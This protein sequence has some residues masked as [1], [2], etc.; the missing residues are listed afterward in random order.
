MFGNAAPP[1]SLLREESRERSSL[2]SC[3]LPARARGGGERPCLD[4]A[5]KDTCKTHNF[6]ETLH[7][8]ELGGFSDKHGLRYI[9]SIRYAVQLKPRSC[10]GICGASSGKSTRLQEAPRQLQPHCSLL[11]PPGLPPSRKALFV[12]TT[13]LQAGAPTS[14]QAAQ[15]LLAIA[16]TSLIPLGS[17]KSIS[18]TCPQPLP[19]FASPFTCISA[20]PTSPLWVPVPSSHW[21]P[22]HPGEWA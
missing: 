21:S 6:L 5:F 18:Q 17:P 14:T 22:A 20:L 11:P 9:G 12:P 8:L 4:W 3:Y 2:L 13:L 16:R 10:C 15:H 19:S 7:L 1:A